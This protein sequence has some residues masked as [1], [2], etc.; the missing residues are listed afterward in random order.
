LSNVKH[1]TKGDLLSTKNSGLNFRK[2]SVANGSE[3]VGIFLEKNRIS[4]GIPKF[5]KICHREFPFF[6]TFLP[7]FQGFFGCVIRISEIQQFLNFPETL[8]G[9]FRTFAPVSKLAEYFWNWKRPKFA[10]NVIDIWQVKR[11]WIGDDYMKEGVA[12]NDVHRTNVPDI[13]VAFRHETLVEE[14]STICTAARVWTTPFT[15]VQI[16][17][18]RV[19]NSYSSHDSLSEAKLRTEFTRRQNNYSSMVLIIFKSN[20]MKQC[21]QW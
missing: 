3:F 2:L 8:P 13:R 5:S 9:Y 20:S 10:S 7:E 12:G 14:L 18:A 19:H 6:W 1:G 4:R 15:R 16:H 17:T 21:S 11:H